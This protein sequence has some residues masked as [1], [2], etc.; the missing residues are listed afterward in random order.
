MPLSLPPQLEERI[1]RVRGT[2]AAGGGRYVLYWM[3]TAVRGH[4]NPA[5][6]V[7]LATAGALD[8]PAFV[9]QTFSEGRPFASDRHHRFALE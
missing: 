4:E 5:L 3:R 6:D 9:V 8:L 1:H 2:P 7:A